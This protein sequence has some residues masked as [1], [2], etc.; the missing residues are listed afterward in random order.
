METL[1]IRIKSPE[2]ADTEFVD[3]FKAAQAGKKLAPKKGVHFT[4]LEAV[5]ALLTE[6]R[7]A[8]LHLIRERRPKSINELSKIAGRNFKNVYA[9]VMLL[10]QYGLVRM[11]TA[12]TTSRQKIL[13]PYHAISIHATV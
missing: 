2:Q 5:R 3:A 6:K 4:S 10:K 13:V 9:D 11:E 7:L 8:L 12:A 1:K